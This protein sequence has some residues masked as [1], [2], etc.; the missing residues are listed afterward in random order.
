LKG[1]I[2]INKLLLIHPH[3]NPLPSRERKQKVPSLPWRERARMRGIGKV[4]ISLE[5]VYQLSRFRS[6]SKRAKFS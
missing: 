3:L 2:D 4:K 5:T 6:L 1:C